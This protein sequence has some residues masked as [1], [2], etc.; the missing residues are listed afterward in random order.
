MHSEYRD[1]TVIEL[2]KDKSQGSLNAVY[3]CF[4]VNEQYSQQQLLLTLV[5]LADLGWYD[6]GAS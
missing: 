5:L 1:V 6:I 2:A 3:F 4:I